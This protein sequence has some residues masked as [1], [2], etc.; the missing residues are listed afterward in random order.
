VDKD[1]VG[2]RCGGA[3]VDRAALTA[4]ASGAAAGGGDEVSSQAVVPRRIVKSRG[5]R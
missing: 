4:L 1:N 3:P 2:I 5:R